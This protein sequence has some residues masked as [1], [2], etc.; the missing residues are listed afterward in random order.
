MLKVKSFGEAVSQDKD[1]VEG[2]SMKKI[3]RVVELIYV[4]P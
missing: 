1:F 3:F 4:L 2:L